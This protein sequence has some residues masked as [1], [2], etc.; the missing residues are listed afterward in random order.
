MGSDGRE[1]EVVHLSDAVSSCECDQA[2]N[3][4][5]TV[6]PPWDQYLQGGVKRN[7]REM[8]LLLTYSVLLSRYIRVQFLEGAF[9]VRA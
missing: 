3:D 6:V 7:I 9:C 8:A 2:K 4:K 1:A 5:N